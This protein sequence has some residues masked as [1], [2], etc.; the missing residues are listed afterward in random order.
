MTRRKE[1]K[2]GDRGILRV[3]EPGGLNGVE[4]YS[5]RIEDIN[6]G[7]I[8]CSQP[9]RGQ[10]YVKIWAE[11]VEL[12]YIKGDSVFSLMCEVVEQGK[13]DPPVILLKPASGIYRSD[14]RE[15]VRVH[16]LLDAEILFVKTFPAD[17]EKFWEEHAHNSVRGLILDLSAGGC[18]LS[19]T[20]ACTVGE[21]VLIRFS[22]PEPNPDIFLLQAVIKRV[23]AGSEPGIIVVGLQFINLNDA[24]RDK[25]FRS[26]FCRQ[27][28]LIKKGFYEL[29]EE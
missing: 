14:R 18:R 5:T 28:E 20:E 16:W 1:P 12:T 22:V 6:E 23:E 15:Y 13:G 24:I 11:N 19:L 26:V 29:E 17:V 8:A 25:L 10:V 2:V 4:Y 3:R 9:M 27:R 21:N 7:I